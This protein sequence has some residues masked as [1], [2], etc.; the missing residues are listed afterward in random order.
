MGCA[1]KTKPLDDQL[2]LDLF[3]RGNPT[4]EDVHKGRAQL[5]DVIEPCDRCYAFWHG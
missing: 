2:S 3:E 5:V 1:M 4:W